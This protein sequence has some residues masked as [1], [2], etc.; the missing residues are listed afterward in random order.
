MPPTM[1]ATRAATSATGSAATSVRAS[2]SWARNNFA[3]AIGRVAHG[4]ERIT[5]E[6]RGR[7]LA[8]LVP[9]EDLDCLVDGAAAALRESEAR[10]RDL[11]EG[12]VQGIL[13]TR[14]VKPVF[15]NRSYAEMFG[16]SGPD[17]IVAFESVAALAAPEERARLQAYAEARMQGRA[18]PS[19]YEYRGLR[20][21]GTP[22]WLLN[23]VQ[24][25]DW[26]G[27]PA[28]LSTSLD[29]T[30]RKRAEAEARSLN[31]ELEQRV[32][33]RTSEL[34]SANA[35]LR[36]SEEQLRLLADALP[37]F[38]SYVDADQRYRFNNK[39][40]EETFGVSRK[41][42]HGR[43]IKDVL[44]DERYERVREGVEA[45]LAG[46]RTRREV[47]ITFPG[48]DTRI[49]EDYLVPDVAED[50][51]VRGFFLLA[52]DIT[53]HKRMEEALR[54]ARDT[55]E[56]R[57][58]KRTA[59][60]HEANQGLT[61][62]VARRAR[63]E[64]ALRQSE[65]RL[66]AIMD[67]APVEISLRDPDGRFVL[68]NRAFEHSLGLD[69]EALAGK[70]LAE[71][72]PDEATAPL[73][74]MDRE[75]LR[76][77]KAVR[78][79]VPAFVT[80]GTR[81]F[82]A[83]KFPIRDSSGEIVAIG[84][85]STDITEQRRAEAALRESDQR[86]RS[87]AENIPG[88]VYQRILHG[89]GRTT[90]SYVSPG[91][92]NVMG[93]DAEEVMKRPETLTDNIHPDDREMRRRAIEVSARTLK[94]YD[95]EYRYFTA[96]RGVI[97]IRAFARPRRQ[98]NGDIVWD[99][100]TLD[101]TKRK[102]AEEALEKARDELESRVE[103]R[104]AELRE[105]N[106]RLRREIAERK[107]AE[108]AL[109]D[110]RDQLRLI[111]DNLPVAITYMDSERHFQFA[112]K[113]ARTWYALPPEEILGRSV[114]EIF[115]KSACAK[116]EPRMANAL[117]G[118]SITF[119]ETIDYPDG[120]PRDVEISY[121]PDVSETGKVQ[122]YF[123][124]VQDITERKKIEEELARSEARLKR[125]QKLARIGN[126]VWDEV[127]DE[128]I[129]RSEVISDIYGLPPAA[130]P[131]SSEETLKIVHPDDRD[132]VRKAFA[133]ASAAHRAFD[134]EY[135]IVRPDGE[136]RHVHELSDREHGENGALVRSVGTIQDITEMKQAE[137][138]LRQAQKMEAVGRLT[139]GVAHDF[140][141]LLAV[142]LGN[143][144]YLA[145]RLGAG[146]R[147][148]RA[149][150]RAA[151]RG[152][153]LTARLLAFSRRQ[154]LRPRATDLSDLVAGMS[155]LLARALG[156]TIE[157][158]VGNAPGLWPVLADPGQIENAL[159]NLALNA[160]DAMPDCG[161]LSI[162]TTNATLEEPRPG[163]E[164]RPGDYVVLAVTDTGT[165]MSREVMERAFEPFFTT[166]DAGQGSGLG[167]SMVYGFAQ[168][169][170]GFVSI[171]SEEG[172]GTTLRLYLPRA[173]GAL[174]AANEAPD[175]AA[176]GGRG[177]TILVVEDDP[178]VRALAVTLL[179][180][181]GYQVLA[182]QDAMAALS[183]LHAPS[184]I[185]LVLSDV[186]LP[187]GMCGPDL[188]EEAKRLRPDLRVLFMS[189]YA[190]HP[191]RGSGPLSEAV[192]VLNKPF[193]KR[194]LA[195]RLRAALGCDPA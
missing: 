152:A 148:V 75:V 72:F 89:D 69:N 144:E 80:D 181:L 88:T 24:V 130:L 155:E 87:I 77:G 17:E 164:A 23:R 160:R 73:S 147:H 191:A 136:I 47:T 1:P 187:G 102:H 38:V 153:E 173:E 135:R 52:T 31:E 138:R 67:N 91:V 131:R 114:E 171:E 168:Q 159:L 177:E 98:D 96:A 133:T 57:V 42:M 41:Q 55:L 161:K 20:R 68:V 185:D 145:D 151:E 132:E 178:E 76:S 48:D 13:I 93:L 63:G 111:T 43:H 146:D 126:F 128:P 162:R 58:R 188:V 117:L 134:A 104:T 15:A 99:G 84:T 19:E 28:I 113:A 4:K 107:R 183:F 142:I 150:T 129:Y 166:K 56:L 83:V 137:E 139:G 10:F 149:V 7:P 182:A 95:A 66:K 189:G 2:A 122:G 37:A 21:D 85:I 163:L 40:Y 9:V 119:A 90:Y 156:E 165:G 33:E 112:N 169:S 71:L 62:E 110:S 16:Y 22:I 116:L 195:R 92:S 29:I 176:P 157:L 27:G 158:T 140:N 192:A 123:G 70:T 100:I 78:R 154:P 105:A 39:A 193:R 30:E 127:K 125:A 141:N 194:D 18:A 101:V 35:A 179:E 26:W 172:R 94:P 97:W 51:R 115:G 81:L 174:A 60:L 86:L 54:E 190:N 32:A 49:L 82:L 120:T 106:Q 74:D 6:R 121:I 64:E 61:R 5:I 79:E 36:E 53:E 45:A 118:V 25:V 46:E 143:M 103:E 108:E 65:A 12:S 44:G 109:R 34:H 167:L 184:R 175:T 3:E 124:L 180:N 170:G 50:G 11:T 14:G 186:M 8:V 59:E